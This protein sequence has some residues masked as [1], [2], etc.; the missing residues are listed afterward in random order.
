[1]TTPV[2]NKLAGDLDKP[3]T[4]PVKNKLAG[5]LDKAA[6][7]PVKNKLAGDLDKAATTPVKNKL[8]G[9]LDKDGNAA[10]TQGKQPSGSQSDKT[11]ME[12]E[13]SH[14]FAYFVT[15]VVLVVVFYIAKHNK[16]KIIAFALEGKNSRSTRRPKYS[17]YQKVEQHVLVKEKIF[18]CFLEAMFVLRLILDELPP[19]PGVRPDD[20]PTALQQP[21][22]LPQ[23]VPA[24]LHEIGQ[25]EGG[26]AAHPGVAV[27]QCA[28]VALRGALYF[29]RHLVK[30]VSERGLRG[31]GHRDVDVLHSGRRSSIVLGFCGVY[32][33][34]TWEQSFAALLL[35][36]KRCSVTRHK[37]ERLAV[38]DINDEKENGQMSAAVDFHLK[39][40][41]TERRHVRTAQSR[42]FKGASVLINTFVSSSLSKA[43]CSTLSCSTTPPPPTELPSPPSVR[44]CCWHSHICLFQ[45]GGHEEDA[46]PRLTVKGW[47][48]GPSSDL[49]YVVKA[50]KL[51][52][53]SGVV[54]AGLVPRAA[55]MAPDRTLGG[56]NDRAVPETC[57]VMRL[58]RKTF[59]TKV[60]N[61]E[62]LKRAWKEGFQARGRAT[63]KT[64]QLE[65][66]QQQQ[67][68]LLRSNSTNGALPLPHL[69]AD[70][71]QMTRVSRATSAKRSD[72]Q[73]D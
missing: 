64:K 19:E 24:V 72:K 50:D 66:K 40:A 73:A 6:T 67:L 3:A 52:Q 31:V 36:R 23:A 10:E 11:A 47:R 53:H 68:L 30:V 22:G 41:N 26:G 65:E 27:H 69:S 48:H 15:G 58:R 60:S 56:S 61:S 70:A 55:D 18:C 44:S 4:T 7:T 1:A 8:A 21:V 29:I 51:R 49:L 32:D 57:D 12:D 43:S 46:E 42:S 45:L 39:C 20:R 34:V 25:A 38:P 71:F 37:P 2:K 33:A 62:I 54:R 16:R 28:A 13:N 9:D 35:L 17:N 59:S 14:F 63:L 5:D